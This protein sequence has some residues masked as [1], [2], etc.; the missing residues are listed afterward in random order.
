MSDSMD[1]LGQSVSTAPAKKITFGANRGGGVPLLTRRATEPDAEPVTAAAA[2]KAQPPAATPA[3]QQKPA[4]VLAA[5]KAPVTVATTDRETPAR[6]GRG[7][8]GRKKTPPGRTGVLLSYETYQRLEWYQRN[9]DSDS[10][11]TDI[12]LDAVLHVAGRLDDVVGAHTPTGGARGDD[13]F[14]GRRLLRRRH[15]GPTETVSFRPGPID[16]ATVDGLV[17]KHGAANRAHFLEAALIEYLHAKGVPP[18]S[19]L[20][21]EAAR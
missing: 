9:R 3:A 17:E 18:A 5:A 10:T 21:P 14:V 20:S 16:M 2:T 4:V 11:Y 13:L 19:E 7:R 1:G 15:E 12:M 8:G 6:T